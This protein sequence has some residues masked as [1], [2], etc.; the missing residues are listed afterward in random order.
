MRMTITV[1]KTETGAFLVELHEG[2]ERLN[3][4]TTS[5]GELLGTITE[6]ASILDDIATTNLKQ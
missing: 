5:D 3:H 2:D 6:A 4:W 1:T